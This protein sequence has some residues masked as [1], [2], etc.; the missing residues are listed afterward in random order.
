MTATIIDGRQV[1]DKMQAEITEQAA[2][3][4]EK[5]GYP[6]GLGVI[7]VGEDPASQMYV[8]M[9]RRA[10]KRAGIHSIAIDLPATA[11]QDEVLQAVKSLNDDPHIHGILVQLPMPDHIDE[12]TV[13]SAV[14]LD[15]DVDGF[16]P[17]N[18]GALAMKGRTPTFTPATPTGCM[19]LIDEVGVDPSGKQAVVLG[20]SN[21]VG[22]PAALMLIKANATVTVCHSRTPDIVAEVRKADIVIAAIGRA[23]YVKGDWIKPGA[24][25]IDVGTNKIDDPDSENGYKWVGDVDFEAAKDIAGAITIVPGGVGPMTITMLLSNTMKAAQRLA[26]K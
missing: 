10:C 2:A 9:K 5:Q 7:L 20:R 25:I 11:T 22:L 15:K 4:E 8:R 14:S 17:I 12:E 21:I 23:N 6:P 26:Q 16:H 13:L 3:F 1:A 24:V 18:I 19:V